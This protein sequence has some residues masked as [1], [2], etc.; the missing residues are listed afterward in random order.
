MFAWNERAI[1]SK[2]EWETSNTGRE[3]FHL[4]MHTLK[5]TGIFLA[6]VGEEHRRKEKMRRCF[7]PSTHTIRRDA[8]PS[9]ALSLRLS[10]PSDTL[11]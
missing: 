6:F 8:L 1:F 5:W 11:D 2:V 10:E 3:P 9:L 4:C 7:P